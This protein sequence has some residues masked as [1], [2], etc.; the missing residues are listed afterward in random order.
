MRNY[1]LIRGSRYSVVE[2]E[3]IGSENHII[4]DERLS[5]ERVFS[6]RNGAAAINRVV[7]FLAH[8]QDGLHQVLGNGAKDQL[9]GLAN[10]IGKGIAQLCLQ[11][12]KEALALLYTT[13]NEADELS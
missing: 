5:T 9:P 6:S 12:E 10:F 13:T 11:H 1:C 4:C 2:R 3:G 7:T 8:A